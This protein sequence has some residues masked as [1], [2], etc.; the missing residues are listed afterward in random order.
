MRAALAPQKFDPDAHMAT[1]RSFKEAVETHDDADELKKLSDELVHW[2]CAY[3]QALGV[4]E[5]TATAD[6]QPRAPS[7]P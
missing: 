2:N 4:R 7:K 6:E 1:W 5:C 3:Q